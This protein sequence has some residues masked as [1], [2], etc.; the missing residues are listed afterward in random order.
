MGC[1]G[2]RG[3]RVLGAALPAARLAG[4]SMPG[5]NGMVLLEY[6]GPNTG[7]QGFMGP[8]TETK[9]SFKGARR[10]FY[11]DRRDAPEMLKIMADHM[12]IFRV[13]PVKPVKAPVV[14]EMLEEVLEV[15]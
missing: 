5:A 15:A 1:C 4:A 11:V 9:Y 13:V 10:R 6:V 2:G 3:A 12:K 8:V 7:R 14:A